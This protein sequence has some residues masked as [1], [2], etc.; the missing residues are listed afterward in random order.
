MG[1]EV[2]DGP[3]GNSH[4]TETLFGEV[5]HLVENEIFG[6]LSQR[7]R[8]GVVGS[9]YGGTEIENALDS[10]L[11]ENERCGVV[12]VGIDDRHSFDAAVEAI[13]GQLRPSVLFFQGAF[14]VLEAMSK[15]LEGDLGRVA[16]CLPPVLL[17]VIPNS[18]K[19]AEG[20]RFEE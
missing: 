15:D 7:L 5:G 6:G 3:A 1:G 16:Y 4:D 18:S 8:L 12:G 13:F 17:L 10:A 20:G 9:N 11:G 19:I 14:A 2:R